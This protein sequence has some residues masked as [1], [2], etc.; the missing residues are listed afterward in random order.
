MLMLPVPVQAVHT[1]YSKGGRAVEPITAAFPDAIV[2]GGV[3][4]HRRI[5]QCSYH[6]SSGL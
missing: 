6:R 1:M 5:L 2:D 4:P 3:D